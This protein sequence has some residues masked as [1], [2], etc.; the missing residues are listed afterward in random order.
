MVSV[1][2]DFNPQKD[3]YQTGRLRRST[4]VSLRWL[5]IAGQSAALLIIW[6]GFKYS[7]AL[8]P[9]LLLIG[10]STLMNFIIQLRAPLDRR[11]TSLEA[12]LQLIFDVLQISGLIYLTGGMNNPFILL[13]IAP[14]F[15]AAKTLDKTVFAL[16]AAAVAGLSLLLLF[17]HLPLPWADGQAFSLPRIYQYGAWL[18]LLVGMFFTAGYTWR[19]SGQTRRMTRALAAT[20]A[21]LSHE[22][23]LS[24]LGGL[25][26]AAAHELGT[27]LATIQI[28][29]KEIAVSADKGSELL[30]DAELVLSQASRCRDI[31][32]NLAHHGDAGDEVHDNLDL[33]A[34]IKEI[35]EPFVGFGVEITTKLNPPEAE[36]EVPML[37]RHPE[38]VYGLT[39]IVENAVD[40]AKDE[41]SVTGTWSDKAIRIV[42]L[43]DGPG[44]SASVLSKIGEPYISSRPTGDQHAGGMGLGVF[45]AK[46]LIERIGGTAKFSNR[47]DGAG[48]RV[49]MCW[50]Y[51]Q[52]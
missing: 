10:F 41:V 50:P 22:K 9:C 8:L 35:T 17:F 31:L 44:F 11:I 7:F 6:L 26:A 20:E 16:I 42:V 27:P 46:T 18:A 19:A 14:V 33:S 37:V 39:N 32:H 28:T 13:L 5:A 25:A 3:I 12:A 43:D 4:L 38:F 45:I 30:E 2:T 23:K 21:I 48:A 52:K 15:V 34:L 29:A 1:S 49:E 40:F 36:A 51:P 24:A 47:L